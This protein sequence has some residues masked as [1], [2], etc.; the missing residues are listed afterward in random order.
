MHSST[1]DSRNARP[2]Q[3]LVLLLALALCYACALELATRVVLPRISHLEG[4][5]AADYAAARHL[6]PKSADGSVSLLIVGNS[7]LLDGIDRKDLQRRLPL[8][9]VVVYPIE[10]TTYLDWYFGLRRL[11]AEGSRPATVIVALTPQQ[12]LSGSTDGERFARSLMQMSDLPR[13]ARAAKLDAMTTSDYFFA[14][15]SAWLGARTTVRNALL[16]SWLPNAPSLVARFL[17]SH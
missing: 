8:R 5:L 14:N 6:T 1:L 9:H 10:S 13:V 2:N 4:R 12:V 11:F 3:A 16:N 15:L 7:L 17:P